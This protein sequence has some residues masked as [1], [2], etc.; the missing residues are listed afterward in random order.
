MKLE[1]IATSAENS[2]IRAEMWGDFVGW[3]NRRRGENGFLLKQLKENNA[4][5][6]LDV[7]L[8]DGADAIY[9]LQQGI[10]VWAN[11]FDFAFRDK[12][13][14]NAQKH[15]FKLD[16]TDLDWRELSKAYQ[17]ETFDAI[18]CMGNS[19]TCLEGK[20]GQLEALREFY[21]ILRPG[22]VMVV[23]ERNY[24]KILDNREDALA[25]KLHSSGKYLYTGTE[26]VH[27]KFLKITDS[28]IIIEYKHANGNVAYY[29]GHPFKKGD[30]MEMIKGAGFD[31]VQQYSDYEP[32]EDHEADFFNTF[33]SKKLEIVLL[34]GLVLGYG[35]D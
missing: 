35:R 9:L 23:D 5:K 4:H 31:V 34:V 10:D 14:E 20:E 6:V 7:A 24:Q 1:E 18:I 15:G 26:K 22:G 13:V 17:P 11:E 8:G 32:R 3:D 12:A 2:R 25:G 16:P 27:A 33:A 30:L 21:R 19:L 28:V 29:K